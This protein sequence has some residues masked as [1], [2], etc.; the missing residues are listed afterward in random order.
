MLFVRCILVFSQLWIDGKESAAEIFEC[1]CL[2]VSDYECLEDVK[3]HRGISAE[4]K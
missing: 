3:I 2:V 1:G 4:P